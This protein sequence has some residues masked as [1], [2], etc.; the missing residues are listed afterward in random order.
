[1]FMKRSNLLWS[2]IIALLVFNASF[3]QNK[4]SGEFRPGLNFPTQDIGA[5]DLRIGFGFDISMSYSLMKDIDI[6]FGWGLNAFA[7]DDQSNQ[8]F[9][10]SAYT[11][12]L[13]YSRPLKA[14]SI[15]SYFFRL[16]GVYNHIEIEDNIRDITFDTNFNLGYELVAGFNV[17]LGTS[18]LS[19]RPQF[20]Y[21]SASQDYKRQGQII[22]F[23]LK[24]VSFAVA[25]SRTF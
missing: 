2:C 4:W 14:A 16:G 1:M 18:A 13:Q 11:F 15:W 7:S 6:Y 12:G 10:Q 23:E 9:E 5:S 24:Y 22:D 20:S 17:Q 21:R 3:S 8:D 19:L 25:V